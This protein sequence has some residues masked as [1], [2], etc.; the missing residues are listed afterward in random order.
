MS[1]RIRKTHAYGPHRL[2][3]LCEKAFNDLPVVSNKALVTCGICLW[4]LAKEVNTQ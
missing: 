4:R 1:L 2:R 3:T